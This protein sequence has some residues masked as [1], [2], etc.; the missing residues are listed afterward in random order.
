LYSETGE[1]S[2]IRVRNVGI[3]GRF[4]VGGFR[5][6]SPKKK[7]GGQWKVDPE[8]TEGR[9]YAF[10]ML[11]KQIWHETGEAIIK[12]KNTEDVTAMFRDMPYHRE[13]LAVGP[14]PQLILQAIQDRD[15]PKVRSQKQIK[16]I[17]DSIA[18]W[19]Q[20]S[21]ARSRQICRIVRKAKTTEWFCKT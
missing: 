20:V 6:T 13:R 18:G 19:G 7:R 21:I 12:A 16:F 2:G 3:A 9:A 10:A 8:L 4:I 1:N 14:L 15:F 17:A 11:L 5:L